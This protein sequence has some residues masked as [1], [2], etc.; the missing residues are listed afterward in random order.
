[1]IAGVVSGILVAVGTV[2]AD[3]K[4]MIGYGLCTL[5]ALGLAFRFASGT[6]QGTIYPAGVMFALSVIT[7]FGLGAGHFLAQRKA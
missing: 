2:I 3:K 4:R 6:F 7:L 5:V 1:M